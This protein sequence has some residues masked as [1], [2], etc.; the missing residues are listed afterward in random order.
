MKYYVEMITGNGIVSKVIESDKEVD[1][2]VIHNYFKHYYESQV[3]I[4]TF[5]K[6]ID[7]KL[8]SGV[9]YENKD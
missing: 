5:N 8:V 3:A 7:T 2:S 6:V 1:K 4:I 9:Y